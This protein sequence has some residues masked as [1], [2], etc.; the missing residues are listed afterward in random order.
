MFARLFQEIDPIDPFWSQLISDEEP[1]EDKEGN[2]PGG[3]N[4]NP[5]V[6]GRAAQAPAS[7]GDVSQALGG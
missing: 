5:L 7:Q 4:G 3:G 2:S 6:N 1:T